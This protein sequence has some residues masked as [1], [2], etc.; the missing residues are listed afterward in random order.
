MTLCSLLGLGTSKPP[1]PACPLSCWPLKANPSGSLPEL[2]Q[3]S[4]ESPW[5]FIQR[6]FSPLLLPFRAMPGRFTGTLYYGAGGRN[7]DSNSKIETM[8]GR[9]GRRRFRSFVIVTTK[10]LSLTKDVRPR[11]ERPAKAAPP[12]PCPS[13]FC[14]SRVPDTALCN[15]FMQ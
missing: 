14:L 4:Q 15:N 3:R 13:L 2:G 7:W 1:F 8:P 10:L 6:E 9:E 12:I 5:G 11:R